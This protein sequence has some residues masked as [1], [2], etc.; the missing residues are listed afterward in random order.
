ME[1]IGETEKK[2]NDEE[3]RKFRIRG[4]GQIQIRKL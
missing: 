2:F 3:K 4:I 1:A